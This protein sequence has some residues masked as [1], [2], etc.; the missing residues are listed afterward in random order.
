VVEERHDLDVGAVDADLEKVVPES[1]SEVPQ[2]AWSEWSR[3]TSSDRAGRPILL[4]FADVALGAVKVAE[5]TPFV[6][7]DHDELAGS[8]ALTIRF[9]DGVVARSHVVADPR[10]ILAEE[11]RDGHVTLI[12]IEDSTRRRTFLEIG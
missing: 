7:I 5:G 11:D 10:H 12:V 1:A 8:V 6:A 4:R 9:G 3:A 2:D